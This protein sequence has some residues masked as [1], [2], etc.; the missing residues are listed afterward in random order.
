MYSER[1]L[2]SWIYCVL[3]QYTTWNYIMAH[4]NALLVTILPL[5]RS[6]TPSSKCWCVTDNVPSNIISRRIGWWFTYARYYCENVNGLLTFEFR[7]C[8]ELSILH[9]IIWKLHVIV[10]VLVLMFDHPPPFTKEIHKRRP[11]KETAID[12]EKGQRLLALI[13]RYLILAEITP[14]LHCKPAFVF[15]F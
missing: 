9:V 5:W 13:H 2:S 3:A 10:Q 6:M 7:L 15:L 11:N 1:A 4:P 8:Q 14:L 12:R